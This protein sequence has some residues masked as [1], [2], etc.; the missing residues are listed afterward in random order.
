[1]SRQTAAATCLVILALL[2]PGLTAAEVVSFEF[3]VAGMSCSQCAATA[4]EALK[5]VSGVIRAEVD[6]D[7]RT[8]RVVA[9]DE[10][11]REQLRAA[12]AETG[13]EARFPDDRVPGPLTAAERKGLDIAVASRGERVD[14]DR[15]LAHD[16]FTIVDFWAEWCGPCHLLTPELERMVLESDGRIALRTVDLVKWDSPVA[17]QATDEFR[18]EGLPYVRV[19]A[20]GGRFVGAVVGNHPD[21]VREL[22][23]G[24]SE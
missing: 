15:H 13:F 3:E 7:S 23:D 16:K 19:Y 8:A 2:V 18:M 24:A 11:T 1:M 10:V 12:I 20:P 5:K 4:T 22:I 21:K 17:T 9:R 6:F 14:L